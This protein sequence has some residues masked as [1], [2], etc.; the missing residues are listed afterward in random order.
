MSILDPVVLA[1]PFRGTWL[2]RNSPARRVPSHGTDLFATTYA[3]DFVAVRGRRTA[4]VRDWRTLLATEPPQQFL[5]FGRPILAPAAGRV[6]AVHDG[7]V[8]HEARRSP[9]TLLAY[10]LTQAARVRRGAGAVAG[11]H[12]IVELAGG[13]GYVLLAHL[14]AGSVRVAVGDPVDVGQEL[15]DC[16]NSGNSTQPH[17]HLQ[18][19]DAADPYAARGLPMAFRHYRSWR[20]PGD[21]PVEVDRGVPGEAAV[22][23]PAR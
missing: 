4:T 3:I 1:L 16:G 21:P 17:L 20:R 15:A 23:E 9:T 19:M 11:N 8:D 13:R 18:V 2:V 14:R 5:A 6:V 7:E 12:V 22:V 10:A